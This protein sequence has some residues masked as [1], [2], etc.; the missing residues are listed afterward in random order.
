M[1]RMNACLRSLAVC[2]L[3][4]AATVVAGTR[5][6][7]A[8]PKE[9][10][11]SDNPPVAGSPPTT[12]AD[13]V[14]TQ[15]ERD[16]APAARKGATVHGRV[17]NSPGGKGAAGVSVT[18]WRY[19]AGYTRIARTDKLGR[20]SFRG[21]PAT[22]YGYTLSVNLPA[23]V[24][25][26]RNFV[27]VGEK[28]VWN[29]DLYV[30]VGEKDVWADDL[31]V[32]QP[33]S[34]S[35]VVRDLETGKPV[36]GVGVYFSTADR[37]R[38]WIPTDAQGR[39]RLY[40]APREV[41]LLCAGTRER[42]YAE[43]ERKTITVQA[44]QHLNVD[45]EVLS[46]PAFAGRILLPSGKP[47]ANLDV[48][49]IV[50]WCSAL[51]QDKR[52]AE[53]QERRRNRPP[54]LYENKF[55]RFLAEDL[56]TG[57]SPGAVGFPARTDHE[58]RFQVYLRQTRLT[59]EYSTIEITIYARTAD[60]SLALM[61]LVE[62]TTVDSPPDS[63]ELKLVPTGVAEFMVVDPDGQPIA[64]TKLDT[65]TVKFGVSSQRT[66]PLAQ[67]RFEALGDGR[68][69]ATG[70]ISGWGYGIFAKAEGYRCRNQL[71]ETVE[72]GETLDWGTLR[73]DWQSEKAVPGLVE[74]LSSKD[75]SVRGVACRHLNELGPDAA[76]AVATLIHVLNNDPVDAVRG[77]AAL[78]LGAIGPAAEV[79]VPDLTRALRRD[80]LATPGGAAA[81]LGRIGP[82]GKVAVP[83]LMHALR[84]HGD[85]RVRL[86]ATRSL[87][88]LGDPV[89]A[90]ALMHA[91]LHDPWLDVR[92]NA[93]RSLGM[94]GDPVAFPAMKSALMDGHYGVREAALK[95]LAKPVFRSA[96]PEVAT[97]LRFAPFIRETK[98]VTLALGAIEA[99]GAEGIAPITVVIQQARSGD[100]QPEI[101]L[102]VV[103]AFTGRRFAN[104]EEV[105]AWRWRF[106]LSP[107][108]ASPADRN[109][110]TLEALWA[111]L[112]EPVGP[113]ACRAMTL[114]AA[115]GDDAVS[116]IGRSVK[117]VSAETTRMKSLVAELDHDKYATRHQAKLELLRLGR[118]AESHLRKA[119]G[120][121]PSFES[122]TSIEQLL[123]ACTKPYPTLPEAQRTARAIR[124][125]ELIGT[126]QSVAILR[127][128]ARG[129]SK[130]S[131]TEQAQ[132]ALRRLGKGQ[133]GVPNSADQTRR[134]VESP[135]AVDKADSAETE[136]TEKEAAA[137]ANKGRDRAGA[138]IALPGDVDAREQ[139]LR[140]ERIARLHKEEQAKQLPYLYRDLAPRYMS[141]F[142]EMIIS[143]H[144][145][146]ILDPKDLGFPEGRTTDTYADQLANAAGKLSPEEVADAVKDNMWLNVAARAR[147]LWVFGRHAEAVD[148]FLQ[149]DLDSRDAPAVRRAA[150]T[151][152]SLG[153]TSFSGKLLQMYLA[154]DELS[155]E[156][157]PP[158]LFMDHSD[159]VE[160]LLRKV[161]KDPQLLIRCAGLFH[162]PL[163]R[164]PAHPVLLKLVSSEDK[165]ISYHA[166]RALLECKDRDLVPLAA[167]FAKDSDPRFRE[168]AAYWASNMEPGDFKS[169]REDLLPLLT[170]ADG[171]VSFDAL[172]YF[173]QQ[174]D[175]AAGPILLDFLRRPRMYEPHKVKIMQ[176]LHA[177]TGTHF[178]Y[179]MHNW[180]PGG[181]PSNREA[182][183]KLEAWL[184]TLH[185]DDK[186][187][188]W[189][190]D[191]SGGSVPVVIGAA[192]EADRIVPVSAT[193]PSAKKGV[194]VTGRVLDTP[195]GKGLPGATVTLYH[196]QTGNLRSTTTDKDGSYTFANVAS[197]AHIQGVKL[198]LPLG[199]WSQ[200][201]RASFHVGEADISAG[202][203]YARTGQ[204]VTGTIREAT[205]GQPA[206]GARIDV[207]GDWFAS[208]A[209]GQYTLHVL[210]GEVEVTC[211]GTEERYYVPR[212]EPKK[213]VT[214]QRGARID[215][216][217]FKVR[218]GKQ[219]VGRVTL[220]DGKAAAG[221][222]VAVL[223]EWKGPIEPPGGGMRGSLN[224]LT[225]LHLRLTTDAEG[226]FYAYFRRPR[227]ILGPPLHYR[228]V[229]VMVAATTPDRAMGIAKKVNADG[230]EP[231]LPM[232]AMELGK[233]ASMTAR[234]VDGQ[235]KGV[236]GATFYA[237]RL[238]RK[239]S[240]YGMQDDDGVTT[241]H[242]GDGHYR[243]KG[244]VPGAQYYFQ[245]QAPRY[246]S[247]RV[248]LN[249]NSSNF[250]LSPGEV[251][252]MGTMRLEP[253]A[254]KRGQGKRRDKPAWDW[255]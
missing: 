108:T 253:L 113:D 150:G 58:G 84:N 252:D 218:S 233:A 204:T 225:D 72:P 156:V 135:P 1:T 17:L 130:A 29:G 103:N 81:A 111:K 38:D 138:P 192:G 51:A 50:Q 20:Y 47:A 66:P 30:P 241:Q 69:R 55:R 31:Y 187:G 231:D 21:V 15:G 24:H 235:G 95:E 228:G 220:P 209:Q 234:L 217:D 101:A 13:P 73:L 116:F 227:Q 144:R 64:D 244:L 182:I 96:E 226:K 124:V 202:D 254:K 197:H 67:P 223:I 229:Q 49:C 53:A 245:L 114:M 147:A 63:V 140:I 28:D 104:L 71:H 98:T 194:T 7:A 26:D 172:L 93:A 109:A 120:A 207:D 48:C 75:R 134:N 203:L 165:E 52:I 11:A 210:P 151:I 61:K 89:A 171:K 142:V 222:D 198:Q 90:P 158:L 79:A 137:R 118:A 112:A 78:A 188:V 161:E 199:V 115:H 160:P 214:V 159:L 119:L 25:N 70:L 201:R 41:E 255:E 91:L 208:D 92:V 33:Q 10:P 186:V 175:L 99:A 59:D 110:A 27:A 74:K 240:I 153:R 102:R 148:K 168:I 206:G 88:L 76:K 236:A 19:G 45:Y 149:S 77:Q 34:V 179:D 107:P 132:A 62:T 37:N 219:F 221:V 230:D 248:Y 195:G 44:G 12:P 164:Q 9:P 36:A 249:S 4:T 141:P 212:L 163:Y 32:S 191:S 97:L 23:G 6:V 54:S 139:F 183:E 176:P 127:D 189:Q 121:S 146:N 133:Q 39:F 85:I 247:K 180:G 251:R 205:T 196:G 42:Y 185:S 94:L 250:R 246:T 190:G 128:L 125:L 215:S 174:K 213:S 193:P 177:L 60:Q 14:L 83:G 232:I 152:N 237:G 239:G 8:Q 200:G 178:G 170:D 242:L 87:E 131:A 43:P 82:A 238:Q 105:L 57:G 169:I 5:I 166:A 122:R 154:D 181:R 40:A 216:V 184:R 35:G 100:A 106:P 224:P 157:W 80:K 65:R 126:D 167:K 129:I 173:A 86:S 162:R 211:F 136:R 243:M 56:R 3:L 117:P 123:G 16:A 22:D 46:A 143:S 2:V 145:R 155:K 18:L 68:Y